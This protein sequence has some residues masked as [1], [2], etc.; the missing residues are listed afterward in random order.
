[1]HVCVRCHGPAHHSVS[2]PRSGEQIWI[3]DRDWE[4]L[5]ELRKGPVRRAIDDWLL[6]VRTRAA[7]RRSYIG[8]R[9]TARFRHT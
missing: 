5:V 4:I 3:C 7:A 8:F 9:R 6:Q 2:N 1:M